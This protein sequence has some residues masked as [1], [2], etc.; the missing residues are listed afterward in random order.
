MAGGIGGLSGT[1][2]GTVLISMLTNV[3]NNIAFRYNLQSTYYK[4]IITGLLLVSA[5][6]FYRKRS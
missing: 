1:F 4:D 3:L 6:F 2:A 5:M